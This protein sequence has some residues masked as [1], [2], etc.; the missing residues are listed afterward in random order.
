MMPSHWLFA[1][2]PVPLDYAIRRGDGVAGGA[3]TAGRP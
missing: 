3:E 2:Y 1:F